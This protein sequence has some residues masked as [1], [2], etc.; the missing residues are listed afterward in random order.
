VSKSTDGVEIDPAAFL[1][2]TCNR[3]SAVEGVDLLVS[4]ILEAMLN[5]SAGPSAG[6]LTAREALRKLAATRAASGRPEATPT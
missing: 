2:R 3:L 1:K 4:S 5:S 6:V